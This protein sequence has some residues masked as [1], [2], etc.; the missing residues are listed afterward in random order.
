MWLF[1]LFIFLYLIFF[2]IV[3]HFL[4]FS[5]VDEKWIILK[6]KR[7][8]SMFDS[9]KVMSR[10]ESIAWV[11]SI[12]KNALTQ[13]IEKVVTVPSPILMWFIW[14]WLY[15]CATCTSSIQPIGI[16]SLESYEK[17]VAYLIQSFFVCLSDIFG[18][19]CVYFEQNNE[20]NKKK[21]RK[22][23]NETKKIM[24]LLMMIG[25]HLVGVKS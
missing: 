11:N 2:F 6:Q 9:H 8:Q 3:F 19:Y 1:S 21:K 25:V 17:R 4:I 20:W 22:R 15:S 12:E 7:H 13:R 24:S 14:L 16:V 5:L 10:N 23:T 18:L